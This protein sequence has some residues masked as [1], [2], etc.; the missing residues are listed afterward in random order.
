MKEAFQKPKACS[1]TELAIRYNPH[2]SVKSCRR[3]LFEWI[4]INIQLTA[5]LSAT[6]W[7]RQ[8]RILTPHQVGIIYE[9]L[10]EP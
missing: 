1:L 10:G 7:T 9:Y 8:T 2:L 6:G 5:E 4:S 3:I